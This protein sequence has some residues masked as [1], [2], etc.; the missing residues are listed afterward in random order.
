MRAGGGWR[1]LAKAFEG[2]LLVV[3][4]GCLGL[5]GR[6]RGMIAS[7]LGGRQWASTRAASAVEWHRSCVSLKW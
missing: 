6:L 3:C 4:G 2:N 7:A 5:K 1:G